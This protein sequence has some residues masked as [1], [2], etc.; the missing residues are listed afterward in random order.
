MLSSQTKDEVTARAMSELQKI[1]LNIDNLLAK[2]DEQLE[3]MI[4]PC[5]FYK[6]KV[7]YIKKTSQ[8]LKEKYDCDIPNSVGELLALPGVGPKMAYCKCFN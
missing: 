4:Y 5:S 3:K 2:P 1:P 8:I 6:R 7:I